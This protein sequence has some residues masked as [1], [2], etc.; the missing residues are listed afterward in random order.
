MLTPVTV[1]TL[2]VARGK[3]HRQTVGHLHVRL[4]RA[5]TIF[6]LP[7]STKQQEARLRPLPLKHS[8]EVRTNRRRLGD[9][10]L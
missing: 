4:A 7:F 6:S 5:P 1:V 9:T 3:G 8:C 2:L 10:Q